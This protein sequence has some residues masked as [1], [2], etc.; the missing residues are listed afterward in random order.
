MRV[1]RGQA[2]ADLES[3]RFPMGRHRVSIGSLE[4]MGGLQAASTHSW[5]GPWDRVTPKLILIQGQNL[6]ESCLEAV[7]GMQLTGAWGQ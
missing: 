6:K 2:L 4:R 1:G 5:V 7:P 3:L